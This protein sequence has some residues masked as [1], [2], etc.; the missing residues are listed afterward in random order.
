MRDRHGR[1]RIDVFHNSEIFDPDFLSKMRAPFPIG[2]RHYDD[3]IHLQICSKNAR[4]I[5]G[6]SNK[7]TVLAI[8]HNMWDSIQM[9]GRIQ[10]E[11]ANGVL[12]GSTTSRGWDTVHGDVS[13]WKH[14]P[15]YWPFVIWGTIAFIIMS[16]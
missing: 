9:E 15:P 6:Y 7:L 14:F 2:F 12:V 4:K 10:M 16:L 8:G 3:G 11:V 1:I 13:K 5:H